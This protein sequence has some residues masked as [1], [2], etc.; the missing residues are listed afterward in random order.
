MAVL[1]NLLRAKPSASALTLE[2]TTMCQK[3]RPSQWIATLPDNEKDEI[4]NGA[5]ELAPKVKEQYKETQV[6]LQQ[7]IEKKL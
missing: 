4:L 2:I 5:R 1:D 7:E 3:N 6:K